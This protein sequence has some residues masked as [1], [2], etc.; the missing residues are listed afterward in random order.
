MGKN[1]SNGNNKKRH[2][3]R[4]IIL[5]IAVIA[6][7]VWI[8]PKIIRILTVL[9]SSANAMKHIIHAVLIVIA[10]AAIF[11]GLRVLRSR[12]KKLEDPIYRMKRF[13][14]NGLFAEQTERAA[15]SCEELIVFKNCHRLGAIADETEREIIADMYRKAGNRYEA[16]CR[17]LEHFDYVTYQVPDEETLRYV[18]ESLDAIED[19]VSKLNRYSKLRSAA[20]IAEGAP[21]DDNMADMAGQGKASKRTGK[22]KERLGKV[23]EE[24]IDRRYNA[25]EKLE[26]RS[27]SN[28]I[29]IATLVV[30][31]VAA[32]ACIWEIAQI[33]RAYSGTRA[34][35]LECVKERFDE[36]RSQIVQDETNTVYIE[37]QEIVIGKTTVA[38]FLENT[39]FEVDVAGSY[40]RN[41]T[42]AYRDYMKL[43]TQDILE[44]NI[45]A[46][47]SEGAVEIQIEGQPR[48][49]L[50]YYDSAIWADDT[51]YGKLLP[52][53]EC[54]ISGFWIE[55][56]D[57][58]DTYDMSY[59]GV[60][61]DMSNEEIS[62]ILGEGERADYL[63][64]STSTV[65]QW[66]MGRYTKL[67]V[68]TNYTGKD[69]TEQSTR[70]FF[71]LAYKPN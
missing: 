51:G 27:R 60:T 56:A 38:E 24:I 41:E 61:Q 29:A 22:I 50:L 36:I 63:E 52:F 45:L 68:Y 39:D 37:G 62:K 43:E 1:K 55:F 4:K 42:S 8:V 6:I 5:V 30:C 11:V 3:L 12:E 28:N 15:K 35:R 32:L 19:I 2:I 57:G 7:L 21:D 13:D 40:V 17:Y 34:E 14:R 47:L 59:D 58:E 71:C 49:M 65:Y 48:P 69:K 26:K 53:E 54:Y 31:C 23:R 33:S 46:E 18:E 16:I 10:A 64:D 9:F 20:H 70:A 66:D 44:T 25:R 67:M